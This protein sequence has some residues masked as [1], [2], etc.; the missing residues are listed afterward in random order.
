MFNNNLLN[1]FYGNKTELSFS[2]K[3][4]KIKRI[5]G[6]IYGA[7]QNEDHVEENI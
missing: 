7:S 1:Y 6:Q 3:R 4:F 5:V 2:W